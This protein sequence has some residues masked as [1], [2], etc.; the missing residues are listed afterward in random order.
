MDIDREAVRVLAVAIGARPAARQLGLNEDT[1]CSW[2]ARFGWFAD[3]QPRQPLPASMQPLA[4]NASKSPA[5]ALQDVMSEMGGQTRLGIAKGLHSAAQ[6]VASLPGES[7][8]AQASDVA[9]LAK[10]ASLVHGWADQRN[11]S[12]RISIYS[13]N[14]PVIDVDAQVLTDAD[15]TAQD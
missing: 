13:D 6:T 3:T 15:S 12:V 14:D 1:V 2:A 8:L 9:S 10:S 7:V 11:Q 5:V 4:S